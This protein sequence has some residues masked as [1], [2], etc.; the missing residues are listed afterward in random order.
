[1]EL[2]DILARQDTPQALPDVVYLDP[3]ESAF[4]LRLELRPGTR[5]LKGG[6]VGPCRCS[7]RGSA[8]WAE[9]WRRRDQRSKYSASAF[10]PVI[11][12]RSPAFGTTS[13][14][15]SMVLW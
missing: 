4:P 9:R 1:M 8:R 14:S 3:V 15:Q 7:R 2:L 5:S 12:A 10:A 11:R 13:V 6:C